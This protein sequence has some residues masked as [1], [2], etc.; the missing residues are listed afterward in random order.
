MIR[1][2]GYY[3]EEDEEEDDEGERVNKINKNIVQ[4]NQEAIDIMNES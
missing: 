2:H 4:L 3:K 1:E